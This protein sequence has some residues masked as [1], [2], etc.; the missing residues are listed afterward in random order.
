MPP[1]SSPLTGHIGVTKMRPA[2]A[3][4]SSE[5]MPEVAVWGAWWLVLVD[6][7][8][9]DVLVVM[10]CTYIGRADTIGP[11]Q[12]VARA[13]LQADLKTSSRHKHGDTG[14]LSLQVPGAL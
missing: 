12:R 9:V 5:E 6:V 7:A 3:A 14:G 8:A 11:R 10:T 13:L 1:A 4:V 2:S